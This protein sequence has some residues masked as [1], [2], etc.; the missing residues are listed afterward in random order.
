[1]LSDTRVGRGGLQ[2]SRTPTHKP[3]ISAEKAH[4]EHTMLPPSLH[5]MRL[6]SIILKKT[7]IRVI[8]VRAAV[9]KPTNQKSL[10]GLDWSGSS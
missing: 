7:S 5:A 3:R 2:D 8:S 1:M 10:G 6:Y 9:Q 4:N